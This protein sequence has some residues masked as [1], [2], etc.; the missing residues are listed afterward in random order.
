MLTHRPEDGFKCGAKTQIAKRIN[1][2][3][4]TASA[5]FG[6]DKPKIKN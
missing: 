6:K 3:N 1:N 4:Y 5:N 2:A